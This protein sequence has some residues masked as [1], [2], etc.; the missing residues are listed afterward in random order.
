MKKQTIP[1]RTESKNLI[2]FNTVGSFLTAGLLLFGVASCDS[3][4]RQAETE[5]NT[6]AT[7]EAYD[8]GLEY[9][10]T[11]DNEQVTNTDTD[12]FDR[13][14]EN[15][16]RQWDQDEFNTRM[17]DRGE[18]NEWDT[19][20]DGSL[21]ENEFNEGSRYLQDNQANT[22]NNTETTGTSGTNTSSNLGT[23]DDWDQNGD[24]VITEEEFNNARFNSLD[25]N[26]D[27]SLS[28]DEYNNGSNQINQNTEMN[29]DTTGTGGGY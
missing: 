8:D 17:N 4:E 15:T 24:D 13:W 3:G 5:D 23:F 21:N 2:P 28:T 22:Q 29:T 12:G 14:D 1:N 10:S 25:T 18:F 6:L 7:E 27:G 19:D 9:E 11:Q 16:D 20:R 26:R